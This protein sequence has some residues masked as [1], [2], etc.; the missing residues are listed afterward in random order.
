MTN[1]NLSQA[2]PPSNF[3]RSSNPTSGNICSESSNSSFLKPKDPGQSA[4][5]TEL[6]S[7]LGSISGFD[8]GDL[9]RY[10]QIPAAFL[11][12]EGDERWTGRRDSCTMTAEVLSAL[13]VPRTDSPLSS[14]RSK[15]D[16]ATITG[17]NLLKSSVH[18]CS[19]IPADESSNYYCS[20]VSLLDSGQMQPSHF[21]D[22]ASKLGISMTP[23]DYQ[24]LT[25]PQLAN[26]V[27]DE[28]TETQLLG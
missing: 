23:N 1:V 17:S 21:Q 7:D 8:S 24:L 16:T 9:D 19:P 14:D 27:T 22:V 12:S 26:Y 18:S 4:D 13:S 28:T 25:N 5:N 15:G 11:E 10:L 3:P 6:S 2:P 20:T